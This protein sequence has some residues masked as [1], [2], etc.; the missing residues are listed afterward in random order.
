VNDAKPWLND[1][2]PPS[3]DPSSTQSGVVRALRLSAGSTH[4]SAGHKD[5]NPSAT[6]EMIGELGRNALI[7]LAEMAD[8]ANSRFDPDKGMRWAKH[9][10]AHRRDLITVLLDIMAVTGA[11]DAVDAERR[12][13]HEERTSKSTPSSAAG[14]TGTNG[15]GNGTGHR[16][17]RR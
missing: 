17:P 8:P 13:L 6:R 2:A 9:I 15:T 14:G 16:P 5:P 10:I 4:S 7:V 3:D 12:R 11:N 1:M